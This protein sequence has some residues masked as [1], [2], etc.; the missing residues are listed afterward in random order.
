[1]RFG[2]ISFDAIGLWPQ[3]WGI[4]IGAAWWLWL[5]PDWLGLLIIL[6]SLFAACWPAWQSVNAV[7]RL[8]RPAFESGSKRLRD[9][10]RR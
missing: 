2:R 3:A 10:V 1:L 5:T 4:A 6:A 8:K 9:S 7:N